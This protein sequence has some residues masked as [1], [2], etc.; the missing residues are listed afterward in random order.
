MNF[1]WGPLSQKVSFL[2]TMR[3]HHIKIRISP[4][5]GKAGPIWYFNISSKEANDVLD[6]RLRLQ[7]P[8]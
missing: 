1:P 6:I 3:I 7:F 2:Y 5:M 8:L 4:Y